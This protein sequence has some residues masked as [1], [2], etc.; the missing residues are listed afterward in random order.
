MNLLFELSG[1]NLSL[2]AAEISCVGKVTRVQNGIAIAEVD[3]PEKTQRLAQTHI[4]GKL[5]GECEG[6][7]EDLCE[8]IKSLE[9]KTD[10]T[11]CC[12]A[13]KI[14]P[15]VINASQLEIEKAAGQLIKGKVS[16]KNPETEY[17]AIF[18]DGRCFFTE[19]LTEIDR[20]SYAYR[21]PQRRAFFHPGVMMPLMAR[22]MVNL[23][24]V[25]KGEL[26]LDPFCGTGGMLLE[27]KI[28]GVKAVGSDFDMEMLSGGI[29]NMP[30][31]AY[32]RADATK[33]PYPDETFDAV[34]T[35]LPYGQSTKIE[36]DSLDALYRNSLS[37]IRR[38]LKTGK[39]AVV[40]THKDIRN[41]A[42][43]YFEISGFFEQRVHKSLTRRILVLS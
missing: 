10:K 18:T 40:V 42:A 12:R 43:D 15:A 4:V 16:L 8:L 22:T 32:L 3:T 28:M 20:G 30:D 39:K 21:N 27:C 19:K 5:L 14:H 41:L 17:R 1:E 11:Y 38:V 23:T 26:L 33:M 6:T 2:A 34:A 29:K 36:A 25:E 24:H 37:E 13:N 9:I 7:L 31:G 35:D